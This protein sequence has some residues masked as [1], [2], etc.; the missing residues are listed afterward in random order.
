MD[1]KVPEELDYRPIGV[2]QPSYQFS[3]LYPQSGGQNTNVSTGG[4]STIFELPA[5][6]PFN[7]A[8]S[9]FQFSFV[10]GIPT[11]YNLRFADFHPWFRQIRVYTRGGL[12]LMNLNEAHRYS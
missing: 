11:H 3:R 4:N 2:S 12:Q 5:G 10:V 1:V 6:K 9:Y 7:F 8:R